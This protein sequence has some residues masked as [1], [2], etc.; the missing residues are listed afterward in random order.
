MVGYLSVYLGSPNGMMPH[1]LTDGLYRNTVAQANKGRETVPRLIECQMASQIAL[2]GYDF[3]AA[4]QVAGLRNVKQSS[5]LAFPF[6][7]FD[8]AEGYV[9]K[10]DMALRLGLLPCDVNPFG[11]VF[12]RDDVVFRQI[13]QISPADAREHRK[14]KQVACMAQAVGRQSALSSFSN[15][16]PVKWRWFTGTFSI[17]C[18]ANGSRFNICFF[19]AS[20]VILC[21]RIR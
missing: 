12:L 7:F 4:A 14:D 11:T 3:K 6:V 9:K 15:C 21:S 18:P 5:V 8:N 20:R 19:N 1:H 10:F 13:C 2:F 16:S 17:L